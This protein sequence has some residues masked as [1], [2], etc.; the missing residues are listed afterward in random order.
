MPLLGSPLRVPHVHSFLTVAQKDVISLSLPLF[1]PLHQLTQG[2]KEMAFPGFVRTAVLPLVAKQVSSL[3]W[4]RYW[5][6][7]PSCSQ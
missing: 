3:E 2:P 4:L 1:P 5:Y 7:A 6:L